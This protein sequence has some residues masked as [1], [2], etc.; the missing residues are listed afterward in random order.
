MPED[1]KK[2]RL[3]YRTAII[4]TVPVIVTDFRVVENFSYQQIQTLRMDNNVIYQVPGRNLYVIIGL[5]FPDGYSINTGLR[6]LHAMMF[7]A[8]IVPIYSPWLNDM[9]IASF[10]QY[11]G[12]AELMGVNTDVN[13]YA[14]RRLTMR[15]VES[16][17]AIG[18]EMEI[19]PMDLDASRLKPQFLV[20]EEAARAKSEFIAKLFELYETM[21]RSEDPLAYLDGFTSIYNDYKRAV[22]NKVVDFLWQSELFKRWISIMYPEGDKSLLPVQGVR[23]KRQLG[24]WKQTPFANIV[25]HY[26]HM[27][28][29]I[30]SLRDEIHKYISDVASSTAK[31]IR[32]YVADYE[33]IQQVGAPRRFFQVLQTLYNSIKGGIRTRIDSALMGTIAFG[34]QIREM[35]LEV[36]LRMDNGQRGKFTNYVHRILSLTAGPNLVVPEM[37]ME[38]E[39]AIVTMSDFLT[40]FFAE[41]GKKLD[42]DSYKIFVD[43]F[44]DVMSE[45]IAYWELFSKVMKYETFDFG[46]Y[47]ATPTRWEYTVTNKF[48]PLKIGDSMAPLLQHLGTDSPIFRVQYAC[49][50]GLAIRQLKQLRD[51][52]DKAVQQINEIGSYFPWITRYI[53]PIILSST[54]GLIEFLGMQHAV[55]DSVSVNP[56]EEA[57][58][59]AEVTCTFVASDITIFDYEQFEFSDTVGANNLSCLL[60]FYAL[61]KWYQE[62]FGK[63][64]PPSGTV[65]ETVQPLKEGEDISKLRIPFKLFDVMESQ[66]VLKRAFHYERTLSRAEN[67]NYYNFTIYHSKSKPVYALNEGVVVGVR[68][69]LID[70]YIVRVKN[71]DFITEYRNLEKLD[72]SVKPGEKVVGGQLLGEARFF[73]SGSYVEPERTGGGGTWQPKR[74]LPETE[75]KG[76]G[77]AWSGPARELE[78]FPYGVLVLFAYKNIPL[79][80]EIYKGKEVIEKA[81]NVSAPKDIYAYF[82]SNTKDDKIT[83]AGHTY[84][85][86]NNPYVQGYVNSVLGGIPILESI[87]N[88]IFDEKTFFDVLIR[89]L[90]EKCMTCVSSFDIAGLEQKLANELGMEPASATDRAVATQEPYVPVLG[91]PYFTHPSLEGIKLPEPQLPPKVEPAPEEGKMELPEEKVEKPQPTASKELPEEVTPAEV[92][93]SELPIIEEGEEED[94][95]L[96]KLIARY[97]ALISQDMRYLQQLPP[98]P[99]VDV[100]AVPTDDELIH[101]KNSGLW[102]HL[103]QHYTEFVKLEAVLSQKFGDEFFKDFDERVKAEREELQKLESDGLYRW[104]VANRYRDIISDEYVTYGIPW[105]SLKD[106]APFE[107]LLPLVKQ[108][109]AVVV[110]LMRNLFELGKGSSERDFWAGASSRFENRLTFFND[111][112]DQIAA[113]YGDNS[114]EIIEFYDNALVKEQDYLLA[115]EEAYESQLVREEKKESLEKKDMPS[116]TIPPA[117][118][119]NRLPELRKKYKEIISYERDLLE[120]AQDLKDPY[121]KNALDEFNKRVANYERDIKEAAGPDLE[122]IYEN[123]IAYETMMLDNYKTKYQKQRAIGDYTKPPMPQHVAPVTVPRAKPVKPP[124][125]IVI[126]PDEVEMWRELLDFMAD[127]YIRGNLF[128]DVDLVSKIDINDIDGSFNA[129]LS[130]IASTRMELVNVDAIAVHITAS[131]PASDNYIG[132]YAR[133]ARSFDLQGGVEKAQR[134]CKGEYSIYH[135]LIGNGFIQHYRDKIRGFDS[136]YDG[137]IMVCRPL[138]QRANH[139][140]GLNHQ[141]ISVAWVGMPFM[142]VL[143]DNRACKYPIQTATPFPHIDFWEYVIEPAYQSLLREHKPP[144]YTALR[145]RAFEILD[146]NGWIESPNKG[147]SNQ[148]VAFTNDF[149]DKVPAYDFTHYI[150]NGGTI[151]WPGW[152][153]LLQGGKMEVKAHAVP[154]VGERKSGI[155]IGKI[156]GKFALQYIYGMSPRAWD[157]LVKVVGVLRMLYSKAFNRNVT[158]GGHSELYTLLDTSHR[159]TGK[160][161]PGF[162]LRGKS[163]GNY[164]LIPEIRKGAGAY[165]PDLGYE[166]W[167]SPTA[168]K[169]W[170]RY[171]KAV[172]KAIGES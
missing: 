132:G 161:C 48:V 67:E 24:I 10:D 16:P 117:G 147:L 64:L 38:G 41:L 109:H 22:A 105:Q 140:E 151:T 95:L 76:G 53:E 6:E 108:R 162:N 165:L 135:I 169:Y 104:V 137:L 74:N 163:R 167:L 8:P 58:M 111:A 136:K 156:G 129:I 92:P 130:E 32:D 47:R 139:I 39:S 97:M 146:D 43:L 86:K 99:V 142:Q 91:R 88:R 55:L 65:T 79:D 143:R 145:Q 98:T 15:S 121:W 40:R 20:D 23:L 78:H 112:L 51:D 123:A 90:M 124:T 49:G 155:C 42:S 12:L 94:N 122:K 66:H 37:M 56:M 128:K 61:R 81:A 172:I 107:E 28:D 93:S 96:N 57:A 170:E 52:V 13:I 103:K 154:G 106:Q 72:E 133:L 33:Q 75:P 54:D 125:E 5:E 21:K 59:V 35:L 82:W 149:Y 119:P 60:L 159:V 127:S 171:F 152:G 157:R 77:G 126:P 62:I 14:L 63:D 50:D 116:S 31:M 87:S 138:T 131:G 45:R 153:D 68:S 36:A 71:G 85:V 144:T 73:G 80:V 44:A 110:S 19:A 26:L 84:D 89:L 69:N 70:G 11:R 46:K 148:I 2:P 4:G 27:A 7:L 115:L 134:K 30:V 158:V 114:M 118:T 34:N 150:A 141:S 9:V 18:V 164:D 160:V 102:E 101:R 25:I 1:S 113:E 168:E 166:L 83:W 120:A 100:E 29:D 17:Y 3:D